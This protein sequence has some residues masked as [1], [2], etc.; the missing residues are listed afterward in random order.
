MSPP[1]LQGRHLITQKLL[2]TTLF[3]CVPSCMPIR[4]DNTG[5]P[6][7]TPTPREEESNSQI[8]GRDLSPKRTTTG[9]SPKAQTDELTVPARPSSSPLPTS[10]TSLTRGIAPSSTQAASLQLNRPRSLNKGKG[11]AVISTMDKKISISENVSK[12]EE[13]RQ[14]NPIYADQDP[15]KINTDSTHQIASPLSKKSPLLPNKAGAE[16]RSPS[17]SI[18]PDEGST[19]KSVMGFGAFTSAK[20]HQLENASKKRSLTSQDGNYTSEEKRHNRE[21]SNEAT[22]LKTASAPNIN[23]TK[24]KWTRWRLEAHR[25][26]YNSSSIYGHLRSDKKRQKA[27][28]NDTLIAGDRPRSAQSPGFTATTSHMDATNGSHNRYAGDESKYSSTTNYYAVVA[29]DGD[30]RSAI[31]F[32]DSTKG[33]NRVESEKAADLSRQKAAR[34]DISPV[35][36]R[37]AEQ[38]G[39]TENSEN[40]GSRVDNNQPIKAQKR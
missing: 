6:R 23:I 18:T 32:Q 36:K 4:N 24:A 35:S 5:L 21:P 37:K 40:E 20:Q 3:F 12:T 25:H 16:T 38:A 39:L 34:L 22:D 10:P 14:K 11:P 30:M 26:H 15:A 1:H 17:R 31:H 19:M 7:G 13:V 33:I 29:Q 2:T 27:Y 8:E 9:T 28:K